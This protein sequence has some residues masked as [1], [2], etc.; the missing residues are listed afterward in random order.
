[1]SHNLTLKFKQCINVL[2]IG[3][4]REET[5][6]KAE[7]EKQEAAQAISNLEK[8]KQDLLQKIGTWN[9]H[10]L[11]TVRRTPLGSVAHQL[12]AK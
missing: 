1:M 10:S 3:E 11:C 9:V 4:K 7:K 8:E 2:F 5:I 6:Q 12:I